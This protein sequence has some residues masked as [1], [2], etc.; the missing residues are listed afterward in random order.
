MNKKAATGLALIMLFALT[1][2]VA[3]QSLS[4]VEDVQFEDVWQEDIND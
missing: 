1:A 2:Y 3:Y 4:A